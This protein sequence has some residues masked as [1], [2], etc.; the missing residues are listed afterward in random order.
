MS[1]I[2]SIS[3]MWSACAQEVETVGQ[4]VHIV[5][6]L[7]ELCQCLCERPLL[8]SHFSHSLHFMDEITVGQKF[9]L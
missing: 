3:S 1:S 9:M 6:S 8:H 2:C 4:E 7:L 5:L